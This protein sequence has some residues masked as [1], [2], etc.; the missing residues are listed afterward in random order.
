MT[1]SWLIAISILLF[2]PLGSYLL[3]LYGDWAGQV[4]SS[5]G[6]KG[7]TKL[8]QSNLDWDIS[9][10][11]LELVSHRYAY[12]KR[13]FALRCHIHASDI[14][15]CYLWDRHKSKCSGGFVGYILNVCMYGTISVSKSTYGREICANSR[16]RKIGCEVV[17]GNSVG[18]SCTAACSNK[19]VYKSVKTNLIPYRDF[20]SYCL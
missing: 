14:K 9:H 16:T 20:L 2:G 1:S 12:Y 7:A 5:E 17:F 10:C 8:S 3:C 4:L 11:V 13:S 18:C 6:S 19:G 15:Y